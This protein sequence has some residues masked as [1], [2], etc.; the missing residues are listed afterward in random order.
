VDAA[1]PV[2]QR[3]TLEGQFNGNIAQEPAVTALCGF[4][5]AVAFG[6]FGV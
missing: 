5:G 2:L 1:I 6:Q 4:F 3:R